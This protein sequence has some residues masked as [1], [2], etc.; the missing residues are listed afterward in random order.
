MDTQT[1]TEVYFTEAATY[2]V[3]VEDAQELEAILE[4]I[5]K[6]GVEGVET[7]GVY[8][9]LVDTSVETWIEENL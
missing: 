6:D 3:L 2:R 7:L 5:D 1:Y 8:A 4:A 9:K